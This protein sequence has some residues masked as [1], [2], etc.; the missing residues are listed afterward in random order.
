KDA[1][2]RADIFAFGSALYEMITGKRAFTGNSQ[3]SLMS[4]IMKD[5]P[6]PISK[7]QPVSPPALDRI[8]KTCLAKDPD[9]RWQN[10]HDLLAELRWIADE[11][12]RGPGTAAQPS[13]QGTF[14][15]W[16]P[17]LLAAGLGAA[18]TLS[19]RRAPREELRVQHLDLAFPG[20]VEPVPYYDSGIALS[21][22]GRLVAMVGVK[23]GPRSVFVRRLQS[24]ET[25][26]IGNGATGAAFSPDATKI[27]VLQAGG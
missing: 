25:I 6:P 8:V 20:D 19:M 18:W 15:R 21:P 9:E 5:E 2:A 16:A 10:A 13:R 14:V 17:W 22:D 23:H 11:R 27:A 24:E 12:M 1:D 26:E 7:V 3:A 4:A